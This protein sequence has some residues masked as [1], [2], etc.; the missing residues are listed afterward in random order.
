MVGCLSL[1]LSRRSLVSYKYKNGFCFYYMVVLR[2]DSIKKD[3]LNGW[4]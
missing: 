2:R 4:K 1:R 3:S